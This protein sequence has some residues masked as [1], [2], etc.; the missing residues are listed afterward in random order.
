MGNQK[1]N[2]AG[3]VGEELRGERIEVVSG[4]GRAGKD[5]EDRERISDRP[6]HFDFGRLS[7]LFFSVVYA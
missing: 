7:F 2:I 6:H 3:Q 5:V 4:R 1:E